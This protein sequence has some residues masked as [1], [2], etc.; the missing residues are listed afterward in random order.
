MKEL[1]D[2]EILYAEDEESIREPFV[3]MLQRRVKSVVAVS[4]GKEGLE[5]FH[6]RHFD[7]IITDI[8]M[9]QMSGLE[10]IAEIRKTNS[11][12]PVI[13]TTA[14]EFKDF[15]IKAIEVGVNKYLVKPI[16]KESL[17][18]ALFEMNNIICFQ[19]K[20]TEHQE[21]IELIIQG[22]NKII[23]WTEND[24]A[25]RIN[26]DFLNYFGF[27][28]REEFYTQ[29]ET[30]V[31]FFIKNSKKTF[32]Y[33]M[34]KDIPWIDSF[35]KMNGIERNTILNM[36]GCTQMTDFSLKVKVFLNNSKIALILKP[37][38]TDNT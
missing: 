5:M 28:S 19:R 36:A 35:M 1:L 27:G 9:P 2:I 34:N 18:T 6:R 23:I 25:N 21:L 16:Q 8:R 20:L 13:V 14:Y 12:I 7:L 32:Q 30:P 31:D 33:N 11:F 37:N 24:L 10:M 3:E 15:L 17:V 26:S 4:N 22:N 29:Y 38:V